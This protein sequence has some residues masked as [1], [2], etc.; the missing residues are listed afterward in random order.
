MEARLNLRT[1]KAR[2]SHLLNFFIIFLAFNSSAQTTS[3]SDDQ[4]YQIPVLFDFSYYVKKSEYGFRYELKENELALENLGRIN[5]ETFALNFIN[6]PEIKKMSSVIGNGNN[7]LEL[8]LPMGFFTEFEVQIINK[9]GR[10]L[11]S[12]V[13]SSE[14]LARFANE[15]KSYVNRKIVKK[16]TIFVLS[17]IDRVIKQILSEKEPTKLCV[18]QKK[19]KWFTRLCSRYFGIIK[20]NKIT[21]IKFDSHRNT[22]FRVLIENDMAPLKG[23][24]IVKEGVPVRAYFE[25][26]TGIVFEINNQ[27]RRLDILEVIRDADN[28]KFF[29]KGNLP[30]G[31]VETER[32]SLSFLSDLVP[33]DNTINDL[34]DFYF[35]T[36][37]ASESVIITEG[38]AGGLF[39]YIFELERVPTESDRIYFRNK[40][41]NATYLNKYKVD[42]YAEKNL[43]FSDTSQV[44]TSADSKEFQ[45]IT[46]LDKK[47]EFNRATIDYEKDG[48]KNRAYFD[49]YRGFSQE[50]SLR[51]TGI[52]THNQFVLL[53]ETSYNK[54]F[55]DFGTRPGSLLFQRLGLGANY[56]KSLTSQV[57][58]VGEILPLET[59]SFSLK[60]R[61]TPGLWNWDESWGTIL[62]Y[63]TVRYDVLSPTLIGMGVFWARSMPKVFDN[64]F[65]FLPYFRYPKWVD[66]DFIYFP[67]SLDSNIR[68]KGSIALNFHGKILWTKRIYGEA[69]FGYKLFSL[70]SLDAQVDVQSAYVNMGLGLNF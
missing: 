26:K 10:T 5:E 30:L 42:S 40:T 36:T 4:N 20:K 64:L 23:N 56:V 46:S 2:V 39:E 8:S 14:S 29:G 68:T 31:A 69:G 18:T 54:W 27:P 28:L 48:I 9:S 41:P 38:E 47:G 16:N 51:L 70:E 17:E 60:Y 65:N 34:R 25:F 12:K 58:Q 24:V 22:H 61:F 52:S 21:E 15:K 62:S 63:Q 37:A 1:I 7:Y 43:K 3:V 59:M 49:V 13:I 53:G 11:F 32:Q 19:E 6:N 55:E 33:F 57:G 45:W 66:M 35:L 50:F 67:V 44:I